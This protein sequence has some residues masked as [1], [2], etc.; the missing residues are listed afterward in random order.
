MWS[1]G[2]V[3]GESIKL[4]RALFWV[5]NPGELGAGASSGS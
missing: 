4:F 2:G 5:V 1:F 3:L